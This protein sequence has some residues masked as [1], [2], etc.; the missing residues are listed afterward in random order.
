MKNYNYVVRQGFDYKVEKPQRQS[1]QITLPYSENGWATMEGISLTEALEV[2]KQSVK[3]ANNVCRK[4]FCRSKY[5]RLRKGTK[6]YNSNLVTL[7][8]KCLELEN[9]IENEH[10]TIDEEKAKIII[11]EAK[12]CMSKVKWLLESEVPQLTYNESSKVELFRGQ[13]WKFF[14]LA[15]QRAN[16]FLNTIPTVNWSKGHSEEEL[17]MGITRETQDKVLTNE[18]TEITN[19]KEW[20]HKDIKVFAKV[21][22]SPFREGE[23]NST[24][25]MSTLEKV[26]YAKKQLEPAVF[27][28]FLKQFKIHEFDKETIRILND[29]Y[30]AIDTYEELRMVKGTKD[31]VSFYEDSE[32]ISVPDFT[33]PEKEV[34]Y[35]DN[36]VSYQ[37]TVSLFGFV[38]TFVFVL[39]IAYDKDK[40][41]NDFELE[42]DELY[43]F[44][45]TKLGFKQT[46]KVKKSKPINI[47][48]V[49]HNGIVDMPKTKTHDCR[50][51]KD[52]VEKKGVYSK[53]FERHLSQVQGGLCTANG[54]IPYDIQWTGKG[55]NSYKISLNISVRDTMALSVSGKSLASIGE[56]IGFKKLK[57]MEETYKNMGKFYREDFNTYM[58]YAM[59]DTEIC[60]LY[61]MSLFGVNKDIPLTL[62][63]RTTS[64]FKQLHKQEA[65]EEYTPEVLQG[66]L[67]SLKGSFKKPVELLKNDEMSDE[68]Y[69]VLLRGVRTITVEDQLSEYEYW[70]RI[71]E[72]APINTYAKDFIAL[73]ADS[74][75]GGL[76]CSYYYGWVLEETYDYDL[77][78][79]YGSAMA[80]L[81]DIAFECKPLKEV[82]NIVLDSMDKAEEVLWT[83]NGKKI[84][85]THPILCEVLKVNNEGNKF[86]S[87]MGI[88]KNGT[89]IFTN[90]F[91]EG[92]GAGKL[93]HAIAPTKLGTTIHSILSMGG[94]VELKKAVILPLRTNK[95]GKTGRSFAN[96]ISKFCAIR[97]DIQ[98][99]FGKK[100]ML[101]LLLKLVINS[102]YGK[103][104][105]SVKPKKV[106]NFLNAVDGNDGG[107][108]LGQ[109]QITNTIFATLITETARTA[110][111]NT[112]YELMSL[113]YKVYSIT[114]DGFITNAP[115]EVLRKTTA[116]G[117]AKYYKEGLK[118]IGNNAEM[119]QVKHCQSILYA[120]TTRVNVGFKRI[121]LMEGVY[122][123]V[124]TNK[125]VFARGGWKIT[126]SEWLLD[127]CTHELDDNGEWNMSSEDLNN[128]DLYKRQL[129]VNVG[130]DLNDKGEVELDSISFEVDPSE[131]EQLEAFVFMK[132]LSKGKVTVKNERKQ[133]NIKDWAVNGVF[134]H[135]YYTMQRTISLNPDGKRSLDFSS[136]EEKTVLLNGENITLA[137]IDTLPLDDLQEWSKY[138]SVLNNNEFVYR[139]EA[140]FKMLFAR[141]SK[142]NKIEITESV[143]KIM[144]KDILMCYI[145][146]QMSCPYF[147]GLSRKEII[148]K[149]NSLLLPTDK[150]L[151][152][153]DY[154][155]LQKK[156]RQQKLKP[157]T[158]NYL[159]RFVE[160][161]EEDFEELPY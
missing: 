47:C 82:N 160:P 10:Y 130:N 85:H 132:Q 139:R 28:E 106:F 38:I 111:I 3:E 18:T 74:Y 86:I 15:Y 29:F 88:H 115:V 158:I 55:N 123:Y 155:N 25:S 146:E 87:A 161:L 17:L 49:A 117:L 131:N 94:T 127:G 77:E 150:K 24:L 26:L 149:L 154:D 103:T 78:Q 79:A 113:G 12:K 73:G 89:I 70:N 13:S 124:H 92:I 41:E 23:H 11:V 21:C 76:N 138:T 156:K 65:L 48:R 34:H 2:V 142:V 104:A 69:D 157:K 84:P 8:E 33:I 46:K 16:A 64:V 27:E 60:C 4:N 145:T 99:K 66:I 151:T 97:K 20:E 59:R 40:V 81:P 90:N 45:L 54:S 31:V 36:I 30:K 39:P 134:P 159:Y 14:H 102:T 80:N 52:E 116:L 110:L 19:D 95:T 75:A 105:Q 152:V 57:L 114:T 63:S 108:E 67:E 137:C 129:F 100:S 122:K 53:L 125:C 96:T 83:V 109:S 1:Y 153:R 37:V 61:C 22:Y 112:V 58:A 148:Q 72:V 98:K 9:V 44:I 135:S 91:E 32:Y 6:R 7:F 120:G 56:A 5:D 118:R 119:W 121:E 35:K 71:T 50:I 147:E 43:K 128:L 93:E 101:D 107:S 141:V 62:M 42:F 140:E 144:A 68:A 143:E 133:T 136:M 126:E 51:S